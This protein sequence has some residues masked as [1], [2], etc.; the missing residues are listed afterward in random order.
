MALT[1]VRRG[2]LR[3]VKRPYPETTSSERLLVIGD[4]WETGAE[5]VL[6][7]F[8]EDESDYYELGP[9][10]ASSPYPEWQIAEQCDAA[11]V[12]P[13]ETNLVGF[14]TSPDAY[15][16]SCT[17]ELERFECAMFPR[18]QVRTYRKVMIR[19]GYSGFSTSQTIRYM[20]FSSEDPRTVRAE[21]DARMA[22]EAA[23]RKA[24]ADKLAADEAYLASLNVEQLRSELGKRRSR[25]D[26]N[27]FTYE[28]VKRCTAQLEIR[29]QKERDSEWATLLSRIPIGAT[30]LIPEVPTVLRTLENLRD[31]EGESE[32]IKRAHL[33]WTIRQFGRSIPGT[34]AHLVSVIGVPWCDKTTPIVHRTVTV[35]FDTGRSSEWSAQ[36]LAV[37][38]E[39]HTVIGWPEI[40]ARQKLMDRLSSQ[41]SL[42]HVFR[43][44]DGEQSYWVGYP[45]FG[46]EVLVLDSE[47]KLVRRKKVLEAAL[48]AYYKHRGY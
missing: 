5:T 6:R 26:D 32:D 22:R 17:V 42:C 35:Q 37:L 45:R 14:T 38:C 31:C 8:D 24:A 9:V 30:L 15:D 4:H 18:E 46:S 33:D 27:S 39:K 34:P 36:K 7:V 44:Q 16:Y 21:F 28:D 40:K 23:E 20:G 12:D 1:L 25:E 10:S 48:A 13:S 29:E 11:L 3:F 19:G 2:S 47:A 43:Y 41:D